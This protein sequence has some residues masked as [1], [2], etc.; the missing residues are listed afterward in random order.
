V[1]HLLQADAF[2]LDDYG[3]GKN[4]INSLFLTEKAG[5]YLIINSKTKK[6]Y[7][8][9]TSDLAQR[10]GEHRQNLIKKKRG[11]IKDFHFVP[12]LYFKLFLNETLKDP[13]VS[14]KK[15][16]ANLLDFEVEQPVLEY[17]L[18]PSNPFHYFFYNEKT[19]GQFQLGNTYGG[20]FKSGKKKQPVRFGNYAWESLSIVAQCFNKDRKTIRNK[21]YQGFLTCL[22]LKEFNDFQGEKITRNNVQMFLC[23]KANELKFMKNQ[24]F[25]K[26]K[27]TKN[28]K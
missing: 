13:S 3:F 10:K 9:S 28:V 19:I 15:Q 25:L 16:I 11:K 24:R 27:N 23:L 12:L 1:I 21:L 26:K 18:N 14:L 6:N 2:V 8:G 4:T 17:F 7:L 20:S 22:T 5:F